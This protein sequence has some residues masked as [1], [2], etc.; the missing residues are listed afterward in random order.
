MKLKT[1]VRVSIYLLVLSLSSGITNAQFQEGQGVSLLGWMDFRSIVNVPNSDLILGNGHIFIGTYRSPGRVHIVDVR[2]P[3]NLR[4]VG[5]Y[6]PSIS[7][8]IMSVKVQGNFLFAALSTRGVGIADVSDPANPREI[9]M[10]T[11]NIRNG[12]HNLFVDG[13][14][15]YLCDNGSGPLHIVNISDPAN[16]FEVATHRPTRGR[17]H[18]L[19]VYENRAYLANLGGGFQILDVS[20]PSNPTILATHAYSGAVTHDAWPSPD[21]NFLLTTDESCAGGHLRIWDISDFDNIRQVGEYQ[22]DG[23]RNLS[24]HKSEWVDNYIFIGYYQKGLRVVDVTD[25]TQPTEVAH[26]NTWDNTRVLLACYEGAWGTVTERAG[27]TF[28]IYV[29]DISTGLWVF[30]LTP[31]KQ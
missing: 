25:P 18:D 9:A 3:Q 24:I 7:G 23:A 10:Y 1:C 21:R 8:L 14:Y 22:A 29:S 6:F 19:A 2:D 4:L 26:Y 15:M 28:R 31:I 30:D 11:E 27:D 12:V 5:T 20:D 16:P 17:T 13:D